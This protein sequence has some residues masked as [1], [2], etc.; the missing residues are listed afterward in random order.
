[1]SFQVLLVLGLLGAQVNRPGAFERYTNDILAKI[2]QAD[3]VLRVKELT[4]ELLATH[5]GVLGDARAAF[6][7]VKTNEGRWSKLLVTPAQQRIADKSL[8]PILV[9]ER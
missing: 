9:I 8:L 4:P 6:V 5:S 1:M 7:V 3:G 2:P